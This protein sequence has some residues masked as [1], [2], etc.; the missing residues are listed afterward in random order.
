MKVTASTLLAA[1]LLYGT[2]EAHLG[3]PSDFLVGGPGRALA[4][5][6]RAQRG[7]GGRGKGPGGGA[8][9]EGCDLKGLREFI[10]T[11]KSECQTACIDQEPPVLEDPLDNDDVLD[12]PVDGPTTDQSD[13]L[14]SVPPQG[15]LPQQAKRRDGAGGKRLPRGGANLDFFLCKMEAMEE[16]RK[17]VLD[18]CQ[19]ECVPDNDVDDDDD[20]A[21]PPDGGDPSAEDDD[22]SLDD[23]NNDG[24][25]NDDD[26]NAGRR[27]RR[28]GRNKGGR[29][30]GGRKNPETK[31][32]MKACMK[33]NR[34]TKE[35]V[36][37]AL[38]AAGCVDPFACER[39]C[40]GE[41]RD[42]WL[43]QA[44]C[45][46]TEEEGETAPIDGVDDAE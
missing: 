3:P 2:T 36:A 40:V 37:D 7:R 6:G 35:V 18:A 26:N 19:L 13:P 10:K 30:K 33:S 46:D 9:P 31:K 23:N 8:W 25:L 29:N 14:D 5:G 45:L 1:A 12:G 43:Q 32:C 22:A 20:T 16:I 39:E 21:A 42:T 41:K 15:G 4:R 27:L 17:G 38:E 28:G 24:S 34:P 11:T 44:G